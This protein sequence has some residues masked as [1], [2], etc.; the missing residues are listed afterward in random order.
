MKLYAV[1][2]SSKSTTLLKA[3]CFR[4]AL[5]RYLEYKRFF[6]HLKLLKVDLWGLGYIGGKEFYTIVDPTRI[7]WKKRK[8]IK[9]GIGPVPL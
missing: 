5:S 1:T 9:A 8:D 3:I 7:I 6:L 2:V 4:C